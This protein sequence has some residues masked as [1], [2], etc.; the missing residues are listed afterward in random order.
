MPGNAG[1][2]RVEK[3]QGGSLASE[4]SRNS[5]SIHQS[6]TLFA[7]CPRALDLGPVASSSLWNNSF[8]RCS[9]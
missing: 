8:Y 3:R 4:Q 1:F 2:G 6:S 9:K 5:S 7:M